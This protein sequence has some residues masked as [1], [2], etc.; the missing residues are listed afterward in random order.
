MAVESLQVCT[1]VDGGGN[2]IATA[3]IQGYILPPEAEPNMNL[4]LTGGFES[5]VALLAFN[6][7]L[8]LMAVGFAVGVVI[9]HIRK[10]R[11]R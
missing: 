5:D 9:S 4:F 6:G 8:L 11:V 1:S 2:C 10:M 7:A 3:W